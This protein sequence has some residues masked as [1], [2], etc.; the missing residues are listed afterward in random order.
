MVLPAGVLQ[1]PIFDVQAPEYLSYGSLGSMIGQELL[2]SSSRSNRDQSLTTRDQHG[3]DKVGRAYDSQGRKGSWW[4][5]QS[6]DAF[7]RLATCY[8]RQYSKFSVKGPDGHVYPLDGNQT[9]DSNLAD[10]GALSQAYAAW[11][12]RFNKKTYNNIL[13][14]GL[15]RWTRDQLFYINFG[16]M[17]CSKNTPEN[18][19]YEVGNIREGM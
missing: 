12:A 3:F 13:L 14:P 17:R 16:R 19:V 8:A 6:V 15:A 11:Q 9:L 7:D 5:N 1:D 4:S 18:A 2:V 10:S